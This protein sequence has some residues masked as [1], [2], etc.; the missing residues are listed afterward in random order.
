MSLIVAEDSVLQSITDPEYSSLICDWIQAD[1]RTP[2][3][4]RLPSGD[5]IQL[6]SVPGFLDSSDSAQLSLLQIMCSQ[7]GTCNR[8]GALRGKYSQ[9][10]AALSCHA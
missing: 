1:Q 8:C 3:W 5:E 6:R 4:Q 9:P 10:P 2:T 7:C